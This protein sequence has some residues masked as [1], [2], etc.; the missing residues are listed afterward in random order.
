MDDWID[1]KKYKR[2]ITYI[3]EYI[4]VLDRQIYRWKDG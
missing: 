4:N 3:E 1:R 2:Q